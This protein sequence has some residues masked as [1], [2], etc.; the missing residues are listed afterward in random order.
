M[1]ERK[2][3]LCVNAQVIHIY[4]QPAFGDHVCKDVIHKGLKGG[5]SVAKPKEHDGWL[6]ESERSN[7]CSL[8]LIIFSNVNVVESPLDVEL[9]KDCGVFHVVNQ[10]RD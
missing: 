7:E 6:E 5:G 10:F 8:P 2:I 4:F 3:A 9:G 1:V